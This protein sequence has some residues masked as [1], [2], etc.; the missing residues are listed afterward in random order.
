MSKPRIPPLV[1]L[2]AALALSAGVQV[3]R[4]ETIVMPYGLSIAIP[5]GWVVDGS[6]QGKL[7]KTGLRRVQLVCESEAC[8]QTQETCTILM[9]AKQM[10]GDDDIA[11]LHS[12]YA[13]PLQ[14]YFRLRAVLRATGRDAGIRKPLDLVRIGDREWYRVETDAR[15]NYKSGLFAE[16]VI[17]GLYVGG[18]CKSCETGEIRHQSGLQILMSLKKSNAASL[19]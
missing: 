2:F 12:L 10:E 9:R 11:K 18:I 15:H 3:S 17:D 13:S 14:Q 19:R 16:T 1:A 4:A 8:K 7:S 6:P 5:E